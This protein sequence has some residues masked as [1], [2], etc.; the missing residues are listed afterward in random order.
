MEAFHL[1]TDFSVNQCTANFLD[2]EIKGI[3]VI[4]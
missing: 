3:I 1:P 4:I 2:N